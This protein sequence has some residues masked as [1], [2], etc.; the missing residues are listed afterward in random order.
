M[1]GAYPV[2][3]SKE[4]DGYFVYIPDFDISTQGKDMLDSIYMARDAIG[5]M[6]IDYQDDG[7][8]IPMP[9]S[10]QYKVEKDDIVTFVDVD[11]DEYRKKAD[12][13]SVKK[14][15]TIPYWLNLEAEKKGINYSKVLQEAL[16]TILEKDKVKG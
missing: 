13:K 5:I 2:L 4:K 1:K 3:I 14:N 10:V 11:Y 7:K 12:N 8:N 16:M 15:C 6:G 9:N